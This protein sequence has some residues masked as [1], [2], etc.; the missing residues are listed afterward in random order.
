VRLFM[1]CLI[2]MCGIHRFV[3]FGRYLVRIFF[4]VVAWAFLAY[5]GMLCPV[6][7]HSVCL[8]RECVGMHDRIYQSACI[9]IY[10]VCRVLEICMR[11]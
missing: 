1:C 4:S 7:N 3:F 9:F 6:Y 10:Y 11:A 2:G 5:T 8:H